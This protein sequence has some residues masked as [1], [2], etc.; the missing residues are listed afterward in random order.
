MNILIDELPTS[1]MIAGSKHQ[2]N[3]GFRTFI[4]IEICIFDQKL[5]DEERILNALSLFYGNRLPDDQALAFEKMMW[6]YRGGKAEK[7]GPAG[8]GM[9]GASLKR[10]YCFEQDAPF[11][12]SAF[13][14]QYRIDL[15]DL[16]SE[17]L[18]WW[19]FKAMFDS[20]DEDLR[21]SKIMSYR[22][23]STTG[24]TKEQKAFYNDMKKAYAL[25][26][27]TSADDTMKLAKRDMDMQK[28]I[29]RRAKEAQ[30][31]KKS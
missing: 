26:V 5:S 4:L 11:I 29:Q 28:Y 10:C 8:K 2:V 21:I 6:F 27:D 9:G 22:V 17:D 25:D 15:Q 14:T 30:H 31:A 1:V 16:R 13:R 3:W 7:K 23:T 24:M 12:Y 20:L 19:K 18:H